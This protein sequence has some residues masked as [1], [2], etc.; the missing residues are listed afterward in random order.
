[1]NPRIRVIEGLT[2]IV[3]VVVLLVLAGYCGA[4]G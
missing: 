3:L 1:M 4:G 2:A